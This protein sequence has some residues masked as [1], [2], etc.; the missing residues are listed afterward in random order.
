MLEPAGDNISILIFDLKIETDIADTQG[1]ER[2][3]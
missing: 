1:K 2:G 3:N